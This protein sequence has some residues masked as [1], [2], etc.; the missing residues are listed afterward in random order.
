MSKFSDYSDAV[1]DAFCLHGR[2]QEIVDRKEEIIRRVGEHHDLSAD[3]IL[4][5]GFSP[6]I[7]ACTAAEIYVAEVSSRVLSWLQL[8]RPEIKLYDQPRQFDFVVAFDEYLTFAESEEAQRKLIE[9]F[10]RHATKLAITTVKDYKNQDFKER[11]YSQPAIIRH[12]GD[13]T[14]YTEIH[15][16]HMTEKNRFESCLYS[17]NGMQSQCRGKFN[18]R[19][20]FFKQLAKFSLDAGAANFLIH[21][22][23]MYKSIIKKNYEHVI[24]IAFGNN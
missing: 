17:L 14:A 15:N 18:R 8:R 1:F 12:D 21:K 4:F 11:E 2:Q 7:L 23:V 5:V 22:N 10:C 3:S 24:S 19:A 13:L 9:Q 16:W 20:L 6:A